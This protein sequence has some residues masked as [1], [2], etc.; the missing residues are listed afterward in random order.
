MATAAPG[1]GSR[2][3]LLPLALSSFLLLLLLLIAPGAAA[4]PWQSCGNTD[5]Y[6]ANST[7][8]SNLASLAK[9]LPANASRSATLFAEGS[10]GA[11]PDAVYAL[12][13]CRGDINATACGACVTTAFQDAQQLCAYNKDAAVFYDA[14][15]LRFSNKD[16]IASAT[17]NGDAIVLMNSQ[18]V[19]PPVRAFDAAVAVLLNAT[20][21]Y[22][23]ANS[24][25]RFATGEEGFDATD[26]TIYGLTQCTPN[27]SPAECRT[28]LRSII[29]DMPQYL[30]GRRG[31]RIIGMR[32][33]FRYDL[34][35]FFS[36]GPSLRLPA[37]SA[38]APAPSPAQVNVTPTVTPTG[39]MSDTNSPS[40]HWWNLFTG[41]SRN[42][43]GIVIAIVLPIVAGVL[44]ITMVCL[45]FLWR[46]RPARDQTSSY[47]VNQSEIESIDSLLLDISMLRAAT[48]NFA[49][50]NRLG[51]GGFGTVYKGVLPDNQEIA[52]K[53]LSQSSGQGIQELKNELVLVAKL[54][55]KNLVRLV[56]V[57]LQEYEKLLVYEYMPNK[58]ID[59][60]LFDSEK[61]KELDWGKRVKIIDG[62][63]RGLQ[64]L[65]EDSQ[66]KI[67]HR[68][69]K[70]SNVLLNSDYTPKISDFGLARLFGGD[71]SREN[72]FFF[73]LQWIY[74]SRVCHAWPLFYK[75][76]KSDVF[77]FGVL[78][79]EIL[80]GRSSSGSFN[81]EQSV[82]LLS[83]VWEHWT[84]GTIVE[85][86]DPSLR[87]KAPAEQM[88]KNV[89]IGLLC[90]QDNP[91][92][93]PKMSTVNIMLSSGTMPLQSPL[94]PAFFI[95][96]SGYYSTVHSE[97]YPI[98]SRSVDN[99][100]PG[101]ISPNEVSITELEPR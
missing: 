45:C 101:A 82:D 58:S 89:H 14:C 69:L 13:L 85:I 48:D 7:Y 90:V 2:S 56:G 35:S 32:C 17:N 31:G 88:L 18:N 84:M 78:I 92:D 41:R 65:H 12:A 70:A 43:T 50:S 55:H 68:D 1:P 39:E 83:L 100:K 24:S 46:R 25:R 80:T 5:N 72:G 57:C 99:G 74:V 16:F 60:I 61:S 20:A 19:S 47:S 53:R 52:V 66:L 26:P 38:P 36:G 67:I 86:M 9:A 51:E 33:N 42:R 54:Q 3:R 77:S 28:C 94:K 62:I 21:D 34:Y 29:S 37:P 49:E 93:R 87:G 81:I 59:T 6:S 73:T 64:Y 95:P 98:A 75:S 40:F 27:M 91:V 11:L 96:K 8:Q 71:Q 63:A 4:Q 30:S 15:Y 23:A 76:I 10:A 44:A 79:L 97:S 22:A